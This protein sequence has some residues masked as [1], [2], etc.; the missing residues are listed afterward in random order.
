MVAAIA[1]AAFVIG[2]LLG[3]IIGYAVH[4]DG[5]QLEFR[6]GGGHMRHWDGPPGQLPQPPQQQPTQSPTQPPAQP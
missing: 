2:G 4:D 1:G 5:P 3:G 6:P